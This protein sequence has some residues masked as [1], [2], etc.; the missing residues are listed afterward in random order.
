MEAAKEAFA[1][2]TTDGGNQR[3]DDW[4]GRVLRSK[5]ARARLVR[6][7]L[8]SS[9]RRGRP[10]ARVPANGTCR[11][12]GPAPRLLDRLADRAPVT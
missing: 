6:P 8:E 5:A 9:P 7:R 3:L 12:T 1:S 11:L 10:T 4:L 2:R